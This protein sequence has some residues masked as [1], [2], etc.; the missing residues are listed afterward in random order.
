[1]EIYS[2]KLYNAQT[3]TAAKFT[4]L[5][6]IS[7]TFLLA[8]FVLLLNVPVFVLLLLAQLALIVVTDISIPFPPSG[9]QFGSFRGVECVQSVS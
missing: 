5:C 8:H 2:S 9:K 1:M 7:F 6:F 3:L 4:H